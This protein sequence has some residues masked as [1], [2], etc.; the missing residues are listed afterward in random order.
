MEELDVKLTRNEISV[1]RQLIHLAVQSRGM[2]V[3]EAAVVIN[4]KL[5]AVLETAAQ[6]NGQAVEARAS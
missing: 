4:R 1:L 2:E 3:A 5:A 6:S